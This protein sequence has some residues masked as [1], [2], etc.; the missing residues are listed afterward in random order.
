MGQ[1][2][3][4][5]WTA[6]GQGPGRGRAGQ[7]GLRGAV[8]H[9]G[10]AQDREGLLPGGLAWPASLGRDIQWGRCPVSGSVGRAGAQPA[11]SH[12]LGRMSFSEAMGILGDRAAPWASRRV[13]LAVGSRP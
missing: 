10:Q 4:Q 12:G 3:A 13:G 1:G 8:Y 11:F 5:A 7:A 2:E 9:G 6:P